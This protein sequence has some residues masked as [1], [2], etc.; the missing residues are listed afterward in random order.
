MD[1]F[2]LRVPLSLS[3]P[4]FYIIQSIPAQQR[5]DFQKPQHCKPCCPHQDFFL[6]AVLNHCPV[7][8]HAG[9][10]PHLE[11]HVQPQPRED[12]LLKFCVCVKKMSKGEVYLGWEGGLF[13]SLF[14][15]SFSR[16]TKTLS[17]NGEK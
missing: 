8:K 15:N 11:Q 9:N 4:Y 2:C 1:F 3:L 16:K 5:H 10:K 6:I 12:F 7:L 17:P 13:Q 14:G